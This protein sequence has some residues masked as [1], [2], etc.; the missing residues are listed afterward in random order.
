MKGIILTSLG[1]TVAKLYEPKVVD[2]GFEI[3]N[4]WADT[5]RSGA[6]EVLEEV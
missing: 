5:M 6:L 4:D 1:H 3:L 2:L